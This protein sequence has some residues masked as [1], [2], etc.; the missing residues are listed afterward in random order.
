MPLAI[1]SALKRGDFIMY[2]TINSP[3][4]DLADNV[5]GIRQRF[6]RKRDRQK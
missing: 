1:F 3:V 5:E 2:R 6:V 4:G